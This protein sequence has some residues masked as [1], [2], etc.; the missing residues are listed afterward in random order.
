[1]PKQLSIYSKY[2]RQKIITIALLTAA[3]FVIVIFAGFPMLVERFYSEEFYPLLCHVLHPVFNLFPFSTGDFIYVIV[4]VY[5]TY[6]LLL[7]IKQIFKKAYLKCGLA[8]TNLLISLQVVIIVFYLFWGLNYYRPPA[9]ALLNLN[10]RD[11]TTA[12]LIKVTGL[13]ID[14]A[15]KTR[16]QLSAIDLKP[17]NDSI[18]RVAVRSIKKMSASSKIFC[19][20]K[21]GI[22]PSAL[23][24]LLNYMS[25]SGYYNPFTGEAQ[26]NYD[27]P[28]FNRPVTACHEIAH[29]MG[30]ATEDEANF[31]GF[32]AC[33]R[34]GNNFF[35]YSAYQLAVG[36]FMHALYLRDSVSNKVLKLKISFAV[37]QDFK[38]EQDYWTGYENRAGLFTGIFYNGFLK[39]NNQPRGLDTYNDMVLLVMGIYNK[40]GSLW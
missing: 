23:T 30:F 13:L 11:F 35:K 20:Y 38:A 8:F 27:I 15:N 12:E 39:V 14:S 2:F 6:R 16:D 24:P 34:S 40:N 33:I 4:I 1:M 5:L 36:E 9:V 7:F 18:Y 28:V 10:G 37:H 19:L 31:V 22:K 21:P 26:M 25:T 3:I 17:A 29:Q 32:L